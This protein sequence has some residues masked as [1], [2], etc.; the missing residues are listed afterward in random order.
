MTPRRIRRAR[1]RPAALV[2]TVEGRLTA[3]DASVI[4]SHWAGL[5]TGFPLILIDNGTTV[6]VIPR[7]R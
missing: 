4:R 2:V 1:R 3:Q 6:T 7:G 5:R